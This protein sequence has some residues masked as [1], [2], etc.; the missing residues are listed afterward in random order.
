MLSFLNSWILICEQVY[1]FE[2]RCLNVFS[3]KI[4][5]DLVWAM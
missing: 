1:H 4:T 5:V 2:F 3:D